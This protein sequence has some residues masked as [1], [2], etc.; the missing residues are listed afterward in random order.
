MRIGFFP[1]SFPAR[2]STRGTV[3]GTENTPNK[4]LSNERMD[5]LGVP[6]AGWC[7]EAKNSDSGN[8]C[9]QSL[10]RREEMFSLP[11]EAKPEQRGEGLHLAEGYTEGRDTSLA[12][13][14][15]WHQSSLLASPQCAR[16]GSQA[17]VS[18][19]PQNHST[20]PCKRRP[21]GEIHHDSSLRRLSWSPSPPEACG[22][23]GMSGTWT[24]NRDP[25]QSED[26]GNG[27]LVLSPVARGRCIWPNPT[28]LQTRFEWLNKDT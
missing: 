16:P 2:P 21:C 10:P 22:G 14:A 1:F 7:S 12:S 6:R 28:S 25:C 19:P 18:V 17:Q 15:L 23:Q 4:Y 26:M 8:I 11:S 24:A 20:S 5:W 3:L 27:S 9:F 13:L